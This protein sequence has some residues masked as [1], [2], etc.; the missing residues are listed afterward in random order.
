MI[1]VYIYQ[2]QFL[3]GDEFDGKIVVDAYGTMEEANKR[4][5]A[6]AKEVKQ[7]FLGCYSDTDIR[8]TY[9]VDRAVISVGNYSDYWEGNIYIREIETHPI[10]TPSE[11]LTSINEVFDDYEDEVLNITDFGNKFNGALITHISRVNHDTFQFWSGDP[12]E[13]DDAE[14]IIVDENMRQHIYSDVINYL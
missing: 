1:K 7:R 12:I 6:D 11:I 8:E 3:E 2:S 14:E 13:D 5:S 10:I 9:G 4:L